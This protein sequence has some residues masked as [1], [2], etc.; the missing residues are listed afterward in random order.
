MPVE[1]QIADDAAP[2]ETE[3]R[4]FR[5][6]ALQQDLISLIGSAADWRSNNPELGFNSTPESDAEEVRGQA[7]LREALQP[8]PRFR[9]RAITS[10][11]LWA[12]GL[13]T[14][15]LNQ[16][17]PIGLPLSDIAFA[18]TVVGSILLI[19]FAFF[20]FPRLG[21]KQF[22]V[23]EQINL[24]FAYALIS[25]LCSGT[26]GSASP[27]IVWFVFTSFY[28]AYLLPP[29][30]AIV[31]VA[32]AILC[33]L[34]TVFMVPSAVTDSTALLL[35]TFTVMCVLLAGTLLR[36]RYI[37]ANVDRAVNF[38]A[39]ADP[40]TGVANLRAFEQ[41]T[42][43]LIKS[44]DRPFALVMVDM[45]GLK[46]A[47][48]VFGHEVGDGM[49]VRL[50]KLMLS[51][52]KPQDQVARIGGDEFALVI[53]GG[54]VREVQ[55]WQEDF[56]EQIANHNLRVRGRLPQI[57]AAVGS[58]VFPVDGRSTDELIDTADRTM[59]AQKDLAVSPPYEIDAPGMANAGRLLR[60]AR[61]VNVPK[62][63]FEARDMLGHAG[64]DWGLLGTLMLLALT[65]P[66]DSIN[67]TGDDRW[68]NCLRSQWLCSA[69]Y[70]IKFGLKRPIL[71]LLDMSS[72][73]FVVV[74]MLATG[75]SDSP[76]Q[77]T[78]M[79]PVA[80]YAQYLPAGRWS[81]DRRRSSSDGIA[82]WAGGDTSQA[83]ESMFAAICCRRSSSSRRFLRLSSREVN[84][85]LRHRPRFGD[86]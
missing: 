77:M 62:R 54:G 58:A 84:N 82:F 4:P 15:I 67:R 16:F 41:F 71:T 9:L 11:V 75:G 33:G 20:G 8:D 55:Q 2:V 70:S 68:R 51:S 74:P 37:E 61:F 22:L 45:N 12:S 63:V 59:Y 72:V 48:T 47:N 26:G 81:C 52:S 5:T 10:A 42:N 78:I 18:V 28:A 44:P 13:I 56:A 3:Y 65:L 49:V 27:T 40:L 38:L 73:P 34:S 24:L 79:L 46:G 29:K 1:E 66:A 17:S 25:Y 60:A 39:L 83:A 32:I 57:S 21:P 86:P 23:A 80:F 76:I 53:R 7:F 36:Q 69:P 31:N 85:A 19:A 30:N 64:L 35:T 6:W 43:Q 14:V 50:A